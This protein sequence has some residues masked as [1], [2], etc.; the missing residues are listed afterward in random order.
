MS[1]TTNSQKMHQ[2]ALFQRSSPEEIRHFDRQL[3][4]ELDN[5]KKAWNEKYEIIDRLPLDGI[6]P[7]NK[8]LPKQPVTP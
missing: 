8:D 3:K 6:D 1:N 2:R 5:F 7:A 4:E